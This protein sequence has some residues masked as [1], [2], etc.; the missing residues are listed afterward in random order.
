MRCCLMGRMQCRMY[1]V[2]LR[3]AILRE[4][5]CEL[6][7][8]KRGSIDCVKNPSEGQLKRQVRDPSQVRNGSHIC[9]KL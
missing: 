7:R 8:Q 2:V 3:F 9:P 6:D 1:T 4:W 5:A